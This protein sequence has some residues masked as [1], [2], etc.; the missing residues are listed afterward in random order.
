MSIK[1][2]QAS[3]PDTSEQRFGAKALAAHDP[4]RTTHQNQQR[5]L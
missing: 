5:P 2:A 3:A 4:R 1:I